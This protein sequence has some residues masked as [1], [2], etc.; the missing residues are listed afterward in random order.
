MRTGCFL[1]PEER[2]DI[3][4]KQPEASGKVQA[5]S[6]HEKMWGLGVC[7]REEEKRKGAKKL[8]GNPKTS[9]TKRPRDPVSKMAEV[10]Y[11]SQSLG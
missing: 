5:E 1:G 11:G 10:I 9:G 4:E 8:P 6:G 2:V 7:M 3:R